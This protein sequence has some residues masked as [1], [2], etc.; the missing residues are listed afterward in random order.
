MCYCPSG[1]FNKQTHCSPPGLIRLPRRYILLVLLTS[2]PN[3]EIS[4][5]S[6]SAYFSCPNCAPNASREPF[7]GHFWALGLV[8]YL[9]A[10]FRPNQ[11][12]IAKLIRGIKRDEQA[13]NKQ[14][15]SMAPCISLAAR[16]VNP[17]CVRPEALTARFNQIRIA[18][19]PLASW[20]SWAAVLGLTCSVFGAPIACLANFR[21]A[22]VIG[23]Q[24][25]AVEPLQC[26]S[27]FR[28]E[29]QMNLVTMINAASVPPK[30]APK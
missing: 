22:L 2:S 1:Y 13:A 27:W 24:D 5:D 8:R 11:S 10:S 26:A 7:K 12:L 14:L 25:W 21:S 15:L 29:A 4:R 19:S 16:K 3:K 18:A 20:Q 6:R 9:R 28:L 23:R 17:I 30:R